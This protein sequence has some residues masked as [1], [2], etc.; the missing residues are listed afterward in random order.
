MP[1]T[2]SSPT[3][4]TAHD[5]RTRRRILLGHLGPNAGPLA[6]HSGQ[7]QS[8]NYP[9]NPYPFRASSAFLYLAGWNHPDV[10]V[11]LGHDSCVLYFDAPGVED[12]VWEGPGPDLEA[13]K[14][15]Y[16]FDEIRPR[17]ELPHGLVD[18]SH[19]DV[20]AAMV[21]M[22]LYHDVAAVAQLRSAVDIS[23][24]AHLRA[25][26]ATRP[27]RHERDIRAELLASI[28][29]D[30]AVPSFQPI[31]STRGEVLHNPHSENALHSRDLLLVDFGAENAEGWAGDLTRTYPVSGKFSPRQKEIY[32]VV[33]AAEVAAIEACHPGVR[34]LDVHMTA[35]RKITEGLVALGLLKGSVELLVQRG[36]HALF[37][38]HGVGHLLGLDVHDM[39]EY[40][41]LAGYPTGRERN[42]QF[43]LN[44]LRLD[45]DLRIEM[46]VTIEP[47]FYWIPQLLENPERTRP[48]EDCLD[49]KTIAAYREVRGIRIEDDV[50]VT[51]EGPVVLSA[52]LP[53][54][55]A[56]LEETIG[57]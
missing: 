42:P 39:E 46:A 17:A 57:K 49:H 19:H 12:A 53:K 18:Q 38:P 9:G 51:A 41:D 56:Q 50:L 11:V 43:G 24:R 34:Y 27:G 20:V 44:F 37:F 7:P 6:I 2:A 29:A 47:G 1:Q 48:F 52:S 10:A 40:G 25:M 36:A 16:G 32:E 26:R 14:S 31:V 21:E 45:R 22:R 54:T 4:T 13:L 55:V 30:D 15:R 8:R 5:Y 23:S 33:L 28:T 35:A 3:V